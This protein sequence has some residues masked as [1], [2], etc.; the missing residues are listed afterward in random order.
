MGFALPFFQVSGGN[1]NMNWSDFPNKLTFGPNLLPKHLN[2]RKTG[3][4]KQG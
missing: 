1:R 3:C 4:Y 2:S